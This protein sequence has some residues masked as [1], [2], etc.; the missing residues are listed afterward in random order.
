MAGQ[1]V[2]M[3]YPLIQA[4]E[5]GFR[6]QSDFILAVGKAAVAAFAIAEACAIFPPLAAYYGRCKDAVNK[7]TDELSKTLLEF[8]DDLKQAVTDHKKGDYQGKTYFGKA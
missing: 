3:D 4:V 1:V 5:K 8:A 2:E 6:Q 7:K